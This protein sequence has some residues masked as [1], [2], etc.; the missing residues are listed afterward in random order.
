MLIWFWIS[1]SIESKKCEVKLSISLYKSISS[2]GQEGDERQAIEPLGLTV[3]LGKRLKFPDDYFTIYNGL[4]F[5]K[6]DLF[7]SQSFFSFTEGSS[8]N[9]SYE[10]SCKII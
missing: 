9:I 3:G 10:T 7:N 8:N 5:Q 2:N 1:L 4:N 6:Y